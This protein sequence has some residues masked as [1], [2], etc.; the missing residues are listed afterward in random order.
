MGS[1][2]WKLVSE[3]EARKRLTLFT[4]DGKR[5][6]KVI[7]MGDLNAAPTFVLNVMKLQ[8]KWDTLDNKRGLK[9]FA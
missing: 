9:S 7:P 8:M 5:W 4:P 3:N 1:G 2:Y 6:W